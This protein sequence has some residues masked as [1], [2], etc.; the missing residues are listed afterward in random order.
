MPLG[1]NLATIAWTC[2]DVRTP[3]GSPG[4]GAVR[5]VWMS[6]REPSLGGRTSKR[7]ASVPSRVP[8]MT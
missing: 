4:R 2:R 5:D 6:R 3:Y 1:A 8:G 7:E